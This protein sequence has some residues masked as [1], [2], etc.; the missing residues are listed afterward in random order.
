MLNERPAYKRRILWIALPLL[1]GMAAA[2]VEQNSKNSEPLELVHA[3]VLRG[4][5]RQGEPVRM[6]EGNVCFRQGQ[7]R[8]CC[9]QAV[10]YTRSERVVFLGQ[11]RIDKQ[12]LFMAANEIDYLSRLRR[13]IARGNVT[14]QDST[15]TLTSR[16]LIYEEDEQIAF[17]RDDV[18]ISDHAESMQLSGD[19]GE[20]NRLIGY[21]KVI[22]NP[23]F[24]R[25][26]TSQTD[27]L[28]IHG[29]GVEM[30][31]FGAS[32]KV[33]DSVRIHQGDLLASCQELV[34][35]DSLQ[36][37]EL[38]GDPR[39]MHR[40]QVLNGDTIRLHLDG[41]KIAW[42]EVGGSARV[43]SDVD[44]LDITHLLTGNRVEIF[45]RD[46]SV[47]TVRISGQATSF[48]YAIDDG[49]VQGLNRATGDRLIL[50]FAE[51]E[52]DQVVIHSDPG[53]AEGILYP[54]DGESI[55]KVESEMEEIS[56]TLRK[57]RM[58]TL[59]P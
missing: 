37:I 59:M 21:A 42:I 1:F 31:D 49:V 22:G 40:E 27:T 7:A 17:A 56:A 8:M 53:V 52:L 54:M 15:R 48:Y 5:E 41:T 33:V 32:V 9:E 47:D 25:V 20:Y 24:T 30:F 6:L 50:V 58:E 23:V 57:P 34:Y 45:L 11:V 39:S 19:S 3:D 4:E 36:T 2:S 28:T 29:L 26:D 12:E 13:Y 55:R 14:L 35:S 43:S 46:N 44:S 16:R 10:H 38:I 51:N 18:L